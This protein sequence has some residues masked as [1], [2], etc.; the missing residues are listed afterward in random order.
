MSESAGDVRKS[1]RSALTVVG[2][3]GRGQ[4]LTV[5]YVLWAN[6]G[7]WGLRNFY[8]KRSWASVLYTGLLIFGTSDW[9]EPRGFVSRPNPVIA[10]ASTVS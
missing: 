10:S 6:G 2:H 3:R 8:L 4:S 5:G 7:F 9:R 1:S